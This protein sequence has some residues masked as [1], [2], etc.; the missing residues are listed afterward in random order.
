M[1]REEEE[2]GGLGLELDKVN[3]ITMSCISPK[4]EIQ[5]IK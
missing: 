2:E 1:D 5:T 4:E 3:E